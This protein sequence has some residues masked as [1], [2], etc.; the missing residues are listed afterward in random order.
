MCDFA[1]AFATCSGD[2]WATTRGMPLSARCPEDRGALEQQLRVAE[3][4]LER[5]GVG[6]GKPETPRTR[7]WH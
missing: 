3:L 1:T 5:F 4:A 6:A 7:R 2:P